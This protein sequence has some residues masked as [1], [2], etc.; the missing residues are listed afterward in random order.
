MIGPGYKKN[1][2]ILLVNEDGDQNQVRKRALIMD[3]AARL[4]EIHQE[5]QCVENKKFEY[6]EK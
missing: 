3:I 6:E 5:I 1:I 4:V 2:H